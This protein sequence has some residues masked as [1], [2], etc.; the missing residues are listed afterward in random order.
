MQDDYYNDKPELSKPEASLRAESLT[1]SWDKL[2]A[3][4][5]TSEGRMALLLLL[6]DMRL[7]FELYLPQ[8]CIARDGTLDIPS[9]IRKGTVFELHNIY[10]ALLEGAPLAGRWEDV[11]PN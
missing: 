2:S 4:S 1:K 9:T 7:R 5:S 3:L 6:D 11:S 10:A 8:V